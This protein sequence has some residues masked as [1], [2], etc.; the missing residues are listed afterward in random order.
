MPSWG[1]AVRGVTQRDIEWYVDL[2]HALWRMNYPGEYTDDGST[3]DPSIIGTGKTNPWN[4]NL[5]LTVG[6]TRL[7]GR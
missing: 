7:W 5:M 3:A 1:F 6:L 2:T 4:G